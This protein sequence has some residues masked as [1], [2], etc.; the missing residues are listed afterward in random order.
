MFENATEANPQRFQDMID[1]LPAAVYTTDAE[2]RITH[3]NP[4]CVALAGRT[5]QVGE[6]WC[7]TWKLYHPDGSPL[8]HDACPMAITL[9]E[10]RAVRG[11]EAIAERPDGTRIW[12]QP[13]PT[14]LFDDAGNL[15]G[16]INM[17]VDITERKQSELLLQ[18]EKQALE[19]VAQ[20]ASLRAVLE[21]LIGTVESQGN[22]TVASFAL[23]NADQTHFT[24]S[25]GPRLPESYHHAVQRMAVASDT[26]SCCRS[27]LSGGPVI[28]PD[29]TADEQWS[30][31]AAFIG[32]LGYRS[33][34]SSL[35]RGSDGKVLGT[36][37]VYGSAPQEPKASD[38]QFVAGITRTVALVI[39]RDR[40]EK[41]QRDSDERYRR[42]ANLLPVAVYT[43]DANGV[44]TYYNPQAAELWGRAPQL[45]DPNER[46]CGSALLLIDGEP[47]PHDRCPMAVALRNGSSFRQE[48]VDIR[49]P[50]GSQV[51]VR[52]NIDPIKDEAGRI[53]GAI[54]VFHD[55]TNLRHA[56]E[57]AARLAAIVQSSDDAIIGKDLNGII[58]SWNEG[59]QRIYGYTETEAVGRPITMLIPLDRQ[60]E[61]TD[62]L[63]RIKRGER[64]EPFETTRQRKDRSFID[65]SVTVSPIKDLKGRIIGASKIARDITER[66]QAEKTQLLLIEELNH[67]VKN[68][69]ASVQAIA[70]RTLRRARDPEEF[71]ISFS[72]R[73]RSLARVHSILSANTWR[74]ADLRELVHDQIMHGAAD[75]SRITVTGPRLQLAPQSALHL[76]L[77]LHEL[78]TNAVKY[79]ALS[80]LEGRVTVGWT[81]EDRTLRL[82]WEERG[83]PPAR[84]PTKRGFGTTLIEQSAKGEGGSAHMLV[85]ANGI[86]WDI[87]LPL[88]QLDAAVSTGPS[89]LPVGGG[90]LARRDLAERSTGKLAGKRFLIVEDEPL[91]A[92]DIADTLAGAGAEVVGSVGSAKEALAA[93]E[94]RQM[95]A[96]LLDGNL[97]GHPVDK[98]AAALTR[99]NVPFVF[100]TGYGRGALP[101]AF[102]NVGILSKPFG[103]PQL[104]EAAARLVEQS[105]TVVRLRD[106]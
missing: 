60:H 32:P 82:R 44:I 73:I 96:A 21:F 46:F 30:R 75:E 39:E 106:N 71:V 67:R 11:A 31:F 105:D 58:T 5:P 98:I 83:G 102:R 34:W 95:D 8:P 3:F 37:C 86:A 65:I 20:G 12:F 47:L 74:S 22:G 29:V 35:V 2:G 53:L 33:A 88:P 68:T 27:V 9:S 101:K 43:C 89:S 94:S 17:L 100:V 99:R 66:K 26:G 92:L 48:I 40:A 16:G 91:V 15:V 18:S 81:V 80:M 50:D 90:D 78:S 45:G 55:V 61:E 42:L 93:V 13:Y 59:A 63:A 104:I 84:V 52:V 51:T 19:L 38:R 25:V 87:T 14:P 54:N 41:A 6:H 4:A 10:K 79:G 103:Q 77:M 72:G 24:S 69:L 36:F 7:V 1:A 76:A 28:I 70:Q 56:E 62:I 23:L 49:K 97:H 85:E 57:A 64:V